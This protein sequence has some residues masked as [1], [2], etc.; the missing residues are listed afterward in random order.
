MD[1]KRLGNHIIEVNVLNRELKVT[2]LPGVSIAKKNSCLPL[3]I[4][5]TRICPH[6]RL[7]RE[8]SL[9]TVL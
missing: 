9:H 1:Y 2:N 4:P 8:V 5:L 6:A 7:L 3:L